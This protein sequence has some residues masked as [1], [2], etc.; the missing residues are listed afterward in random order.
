MNENNSEV[1]E[2]QV[3][4]NFNEIKL[5]VQAYVKIMRDADK[6]YLGLLIVFE[7]LTEL[8]KAQRV[9]A[10]RDV[11]QGIAHEIKNPLTPIQFNTQRLR[12]KYYESKE[13]FALV[14]DESIEIIEQEI[15]DM[16]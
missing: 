12:K 3:E 11:A 14:F 9:A 15:N 8:I 6:S 13:A 10:W 4:I 5:T 1:R 2:E 16:N 7:D